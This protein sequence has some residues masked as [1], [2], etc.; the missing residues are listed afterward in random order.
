MEH[1]PRVDPEPREQHQEP[2]HHTPTNAHEDVHKWAIAIAL[3]N[4][5]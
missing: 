2:A 1:I 4:S 5:S 3:K